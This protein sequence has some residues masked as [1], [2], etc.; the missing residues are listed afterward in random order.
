MEALSTISRGLTVDEPSATGIDPCTD[1]WDASECLACLEAYGSDAPEYD[2]ETELGI[3]MLQRDC[4]R[5]GR[6]RRLSGLR[7]R[8]DPGRVPRDLT[9]WEYPRRRSCCSLTP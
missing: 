8:A 5:L 1:V 7:N 3:A 9:C 6:Q 2:L 4:R